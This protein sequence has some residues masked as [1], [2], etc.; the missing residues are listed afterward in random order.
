MKDQIDR[1]KM[2]MA[3]KHM[4]TCKNCNATYLPMAQIARDICPL[5]NR[6]HVEGLQ[7]ELDSIEILEGEL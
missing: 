4:I 6:E 5:C 1:I 3:N 7:R 2:I